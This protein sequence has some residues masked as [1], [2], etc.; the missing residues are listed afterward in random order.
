MRLRP[1]YPRPRTTRRRLA[2]G[3]KE[4]PFGREVSK[5]LL[6]P[7]GYLYFCL[8]ASFLIVIK[9]SHGQVEMKISFG[10]QLDWFNTTAK[11]QS[12]SCSW[13]RQPRS[14]VD[15]GGL[16]KSSSFRIEE[17]DQIQQE[18]RG[19][20]IFSG[21][22]LPRNSS[23]VRRTCLDVKNSNNFL[24][25]GSLQTLKRRLAVKGDGKRSQNVAEKEKHVDESDHVVDSEHVVKTQSAGL[26]YNLKTK[27]LK[28]KK[29][30]LTAKFS[31]LPSKTKMVF[32]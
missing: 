19:I 16:K 1:L 25:E 12:F 21:F 24:I 28:E 7:I 31:T 23:R 13:R 9:A 26:Y 10:P 2:S 30:D 3:E 22:S 8:A 4:S 11:R 20:K 5:I 6:R 29:S 18:R 32:I 14:N 27:T 17:S 15:G